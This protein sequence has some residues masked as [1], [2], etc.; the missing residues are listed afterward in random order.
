MFSGVCRFTKKLK[1]L[2]KSRIRCIFRVFP[3]HF[4]YFCIRGPSLVELTGNYNSATSTVAVYY[5]LM[6]PKEYVCMAITYK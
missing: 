4:F 5:E 3:G 1:C 6:S 2:L